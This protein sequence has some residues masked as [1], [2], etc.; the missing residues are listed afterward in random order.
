M[1][2]GA[3]VGVFAV[4]STGLLPFELVAA[5]RVSDAVEAESLDGASSFLI[6][7]SFSFSLTGA[8]AT[9]LERCF[10]DSFNVTIRALFDLRRAG[11]SAA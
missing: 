9:K 4:D 8:A 6:S 2:A 1:P 3:G 11:A 10:G 7:F 5:G